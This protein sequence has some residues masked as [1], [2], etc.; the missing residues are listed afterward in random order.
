MSDPKEYFR[1][2]FGAAIKLANELARN[3]SKD[4]DPRH[5]VVVAIPR[6]QGIRPGYR[7]KIY[8]GGPWQVTNPL[9]VVVDHGDVR[10]SYSDGVMT[11]YDRTVHPARVSTERLRP[12]RFRSAKVV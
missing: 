8:E 7:V 1:K 12:N 3:S 10:Y 6:K 11:K 2:H 4:G 9:Y 5:F